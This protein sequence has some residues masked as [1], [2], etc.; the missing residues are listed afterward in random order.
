MW[1]HSFL[2][3]IRP[4][5]EFTSPAKIISSH[6]TM[7]LLGCLCLLT[8]AVAAEPHADTS[9]TISWPLQPDENIEQLAA[10]FYPDNSAMQRHFIR[11]T[12]KLNQSNH[13]EFNATTSSSTGSV[14]IIPTLKQL[15]RHGMA[16]HR[17]PMPTKR[18]STAQDEVMQRRYAVLQENRTVQLEE[19]AQLQNKLD[20]LQAQID[21]L[22]TMLQQRQA[23]EAERQLQPAKIAEKATQPHVKNQNS[24]SRPIPEPEQ[25]LPTS[26]NILLFLLGTLLVIILLSLAK[27]RKSLRGWLKRKPAPKQDDIGNQRQ[28]VVTVMAPISAPV[29][30]P[31]DETP[32]LEAEAAI[33]E[34]KIL[35]DTGNSR[36]ATAV[37]NASITAHP[38]ASIRPWL[39]LLDIYRDLGLREE[40]DSLSLLL[41]HTFNVMQPVWENVEIAMVVSDTLEQFPHIIKK[42]VQ[43]WQ[44]VAT[45]TDYLKT[46][47]TDNRGGE[48]NGFSAAVLEEILLLQDILNLREPGLKPAVDN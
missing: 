12:L 26:S 40:F 17:S 18:K 13:P 9:A 31:E 37:L 29:I 46:L 8:P 34:A 23:E 32:P 22:K 21:Q 4:V 1:R 25:Y 24:T 44:D 33:R 19:A 30:T 16:S 15:S 43:L 41:H 3:N 28:R 14:I 27:Y 45:A 36:A 5:T 10:L 47:L 7:I 11:Q 20:Q 48:R 42:L 6:I 39:Y 38:Q 35:L 2:K